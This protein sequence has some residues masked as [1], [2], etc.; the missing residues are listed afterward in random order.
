MIFEIVK[1]DLEGHIIWLAKRFS[2]K[3]ENSDVIRFW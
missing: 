2:L 1:Y 3:I